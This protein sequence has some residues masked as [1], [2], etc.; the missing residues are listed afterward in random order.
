MKSMGFAYWGCQG[1]Y[2]AVSSPD[3]GATSMWPILRSFQEQGWHTYLMYEDRDRDM[4]QKMGSELFTGACADKR[5]NTYQQVHKTVPCGIEFPELDILLMEW[6]WVIPGYDQ[7]Y[8]QRQQDILEHYS[9]TDTKIFIYD[10]DHKL[11]AEDE[12]R[13]PKAQIVEPSFRPKF[14]TKERKSLHYACDISLLA[15]GQRLV[16][17]DAYMLMYAGNRY[18]RDREVEFW[19]SPVSRNFNVCV[20]GKWEPKDECRQLWPKIQFVE[21]VDASKFPLLIPHAVAVPLLA[22][23]SYHETGLMALR[24]FETV[25]N[26]SIPISLSTFTGAHQITNYVAQDDLHLLE[27]CNKLQAQHIEERLKE[28]MLAI[29]MLEQFSYQNFFRRLTS[30]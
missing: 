11:T 8:L 28:H 27:I 21:R 18:E 29:E 5:L 9:N 25:A 26:G 16:R 24:I 1:D 15:A 7:P 2:R 19:L 14:L 13:W 10:T 17:H 4:Y 30:F 3:G 20:V 12:A 22:K 23:P 6:R